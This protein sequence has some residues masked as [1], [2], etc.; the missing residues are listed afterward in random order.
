MRTALVILELLALVPPLLKLLVA[1]YPKA[2]TTTRRIYLFLYLLIPSLIFVD[3]GHFQP[4]SAMHGL[5]L[6]AVYF[7]IT[8]RIEWA[9]VFMVAA[10]NFKQMALYFAMPFAFMTLGSLYKLAC[11]RF[12]GDKSK[13]IGYMGVRCLGLALVFAATIGVLWYPWVRET[14]L[15]DPSLGASSVLA[16][17]F[18]LRRGLFEDKVAS[19]WCVLNNFV[20]V[21][22]V[23]PQEIQIRLATLLTLVTSLPANVMLVRN[24]SPKN[25]LLCLFTTSL[26]FFLYSFHVH[27]KQILLP[28]LIF[29][30]Q[31]L[32]EFRHY[33]SMFGL[34]A[35][36]SMYHLYCK[37]NNQ[38]NYIALNVIWLVVA[39]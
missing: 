35:N 25:F 16:R 8:Q 13:I 19:F 20:K 7:I 23:F 6:W 28:L 29:G 33:V 37:D 32:T 18:P 24:P 26:C 9:V 39:R 11:Q 1:L 27:E 38:V 2:S 17:I 5:V 15:G 4:N 21:H 31:G 10:V 14:L 36:F 30:L 22:Q 34:V 3:H 12:K